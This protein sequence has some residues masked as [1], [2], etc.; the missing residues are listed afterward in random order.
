MNASGRPD[1]DS[2]VRGQPVLSPI[3]VAARPPR[4]NLAMIAVGSLAVVAAVLGWRWAHRPRVASAAPAPVAAAVAPMPA[5]TLEVTVL[6][7]KS[8]PAPVVAAPAVAPTI[9][10]V[11][12]PPTPPPPAPANR[13]LLRSKK[14]A[15]PTGGRSEP[16]EARPA[17]HL[18]TPPS[19]P[20]TKPEPQ[21][22]AIEANPYLYK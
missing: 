15:R 13:T 18:E 6:E 17:E 2:A 1:V 5:A 8:L 10:P 14:P 7:V 19:P 20:A 21:K 12:P 9:A 3:G 11:E 16:T 22:P 4:A